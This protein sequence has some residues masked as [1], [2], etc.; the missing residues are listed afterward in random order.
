MFIVESPFVCA[1]ILLILEIIA[2]GIGAMICFCEK[3]KKKISCK[4]CNL[5]NNQKDYFKINCWKLYFRVIY[6]TIIITVVTA[7]LILL[8]RTMKGGI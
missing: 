8:M 1:V 4:K 2:L 3:D 6:S 5:E 7:S